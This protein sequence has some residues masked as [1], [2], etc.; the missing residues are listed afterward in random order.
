MGKARI[1]SGGERGLYSIQIRLDTTSIDAERADLLKRIADQQKKVEEAETSY[2]DLQAEVQA[3]AFALNEMITRNAE[4]G[5]DGIDPDADDQTGAAPNPDDLVSL[6]NAIRIDNQLGLLTPNSALDVAA[7][8]HA[9]W[10]AANDVMSHTGENGS[11][12]QERADAAGFVGGV[13]EN[14]A[15]GQDS[16][17]RV[18]PQWMGSPPHRE[19]ILYGPYVH[20]G[21]GY[22][23]VKGSVYEHHW[24]V[25]FGLGAS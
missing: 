5:E 11:T 3:Q 1:L 6:H 4:F 23:Y 16:P 15:V 18:M 9:E 7:Q 13:G 10:M 12:Y 8:E 22:R 21:I 2:R 19:N 24:C 25:L 17:S 20:I 14:V